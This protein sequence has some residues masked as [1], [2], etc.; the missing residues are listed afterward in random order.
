[1]ISSLEGTVTATG[2]SWLLITVGGMGFRVEAA[3][4]LVAKVA[5]ASAVGGAGKEVRTTVHTYLVVREDALTLYGFESSEDRGV[6]ETL[7]SVSGIGPKLAVAAIDTLGVNGLRRAV[8]G[9]DLKELSRIPGVGKKT[10][11]RLVLEIGE[12]LG[13]PQPPESGTPLAGEVT[14]LESQVRES[15]EAALEQLGWPRAVAQRAVDKV[16][17]DKVGGDPHTMETMLRAALATLGTESGRG[18]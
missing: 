13:A 2:P 6:F 7:L 14:P 15:V 11:Q 1:M 10:A 16:A 18:F 4:T 3:P 5:S 8:A 12:K 9:E 17:Q